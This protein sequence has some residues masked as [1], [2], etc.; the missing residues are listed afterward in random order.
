M[1]SGLPCARSRLRNQC[2]CTPGSLSCVRARMGLYTYLPEPAPPMQA[3]DAAPWPSLTAW[4]GVVVVPVPASLLCI[5]STFVCPDVDSCVEAVPV[6][7][8]LAVR[9]AH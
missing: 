7:V 6:C 2:S 5:S 9:G 3:P 1:L 4:H 8:S